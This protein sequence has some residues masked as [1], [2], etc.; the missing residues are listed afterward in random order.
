MSSLYLIISGNLINSTKTDIYSIADK[1]A[2]SEKRNPDTWSGKIQSYWLCK[3]LGEEKYECRECKRNDRVSAQIEARH[4][5]CKVLKKS[6]PPSA[7]PKWLRWTADGS[8]VQLQFSSKDLF[9]ITAKILKHFSLSL[10][11]VKNIPDSTM[12]IITLKIKKEDIV[13]RVIPVRE[14]FNAG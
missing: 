7:V 3:F 8:C 9:L 11:F 10:D 1:I 2:I 6:Y 14:G 13:T 5:L 12:D 4:W